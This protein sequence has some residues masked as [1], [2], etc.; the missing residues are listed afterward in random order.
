MAYIYIDKK[1]E[2]R[3]V[4]IVILQLLKSIAICFA[5][6]YKCIFSSINLHIPAQAHCMYTLIAY[7]D[8]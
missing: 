1:F 4:A 2:K 6:F 7:T 3:L 8:F 5:W